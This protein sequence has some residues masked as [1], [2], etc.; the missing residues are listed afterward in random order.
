[1]FKKY[2]NNLPLWQFEIF[3]SETYVKHFITGREGGVTKGEKG[4]L[5][6]SYNVGDEAENVFH[7]RTALAKAMGIE[8]KCLIFPKQVHGNNVVHIKPDNVDTLSEAGDALITS[9]AGV[10]LMTTAADCVPILL[11][12]PDKKAI[13]AVHAGWRGTVSKIVANTL[14]AM[15]E[16]FGS[17]PQNIKVGIGPSI[18]PEVYEVG[19][20][21]VEAV[22]QVFEDDAA[23][24]L[25]KSGETGRAKFNLWDAN[26]IQLLRLG[27][28]EENI[29]VAGICTFSNQDEFFSARGSKN[30][31]RFAAGILLCR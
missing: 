12:D 1:M 29:E 24:L 19:E 27:V 8:E 11:F 14:T 6:L 17:E 2:I 22:H 31:G 23:Q 26:K 3:A 9:T 10:C 20:E 16:K 13:A 5:N 30:S 18:S 15:K 25:V 28:R 4:S 21:V 7:N